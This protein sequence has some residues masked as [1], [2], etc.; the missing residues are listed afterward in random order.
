ME[1]VV[2]GTWR[3]I[4]PSPWHGEDR[5]GL[6]R[7]SVADPRFQR[8]LVPYTGDSSLGHGHQ[9]SENLDPDL[10]RL[11]LN[12][13]CEHHT[14]RCPTGRQDGYLD[15]LILIDVNQWRVLPLEPDHQPAYTALSYVWSDQSNWKPR[16]VKRTPPSI[17][18]PQTTEDTINLTRNIG[19]GF[20]WIDALCIVQDDLDAQAF[21]IKQEAAW[22]ADVHLEAHSAKTPVDVLSDDNVIQELVENPGTS[23]NEAIVT[24]RH[25]IHKY[26]LRQLTKDS[27]IENALAGVGN[28][29]RSKIGPLYHGILERIFGEIIEGCWCW[30]L[31]QSPRTGWIRERIITTTD[32]LSPADPEIGI[33]PL[34]EVATNKPLLKFFK[35]SDELQPL[36]QPD[37]TGQ[38]NVKQMYDH[39][40]PDISQLQDRYRVMQAAL[41]PSSSMPD[42]IAF[43]R[44]LAILAVERQPHHFVGASYDFPVCHPTTKRRLSSIRLWQGA[45]PRGKFKVHPFIV[46][47]ASEK[48]FRLMMI[49]FEKGV[50]YKVNN[51]TAPGAK[52]KME[53]CWRLGPTKR[54]IITG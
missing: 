20:I 29:L 17:R 36:L 38:N 22:R 4:T 48:A 28:L 42:H 51:V 49:R 23:R 34:G 25:L 45:E 53:D 19:I 33:A 37:T 54:I 3:S 50:A 6:L 10:F 32:T 2:H 39:C 40:I 31:L 43:F 7:P 12:I 16:L 21:Q 14:A 9:M 11:W 26:M 44:S 18:I 24:F 1:V 5:V 35:F 13:C 27:D 30:D 52:V 8:A 41:K 47:S 15:K 46:I